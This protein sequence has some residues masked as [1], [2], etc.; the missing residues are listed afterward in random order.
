M[1]RR[2]RRECG[3]TVLPRRRGAC[4]RLV[5]YTWGNESG[6]TPTPGSKTSRGG[7]VSRCRLPRA[8]LPRAAST[9]TKDKPAWSSRWERS[10]SARRE[11]R[12]KVA[13]TLA[14]GIGQTR[15][16][17]GRT[18]RRV[19]NRLRGSQS[20]N[21]TEATPFHARLSSAPAERVVRWWKENCG[22]GEAEP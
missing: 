15:R 18:C 22:S 20:T 19:A 12:R 9:R 4:L 7:S 3:A 8:A 11:T 6:G 17:A 5:R 2:L 14:E 1:C 21:L 10:A 13:E 16:L